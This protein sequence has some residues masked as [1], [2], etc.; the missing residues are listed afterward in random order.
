LFAPGTN[1]ET[2]LVFFNCEHA[3]VIFFPPGSDELTGFV[4]GPCGGQSPTPIDA[5]RD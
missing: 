1:V 3:F 4:L 5:F 2:T